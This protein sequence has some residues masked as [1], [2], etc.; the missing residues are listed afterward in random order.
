MASRY[1]NLVTAMDVDGAAVSCYGGGMNCVNQVAAPPLVIEQSAGANQLLDVFGVSSE[2]VTQSGERDVFITHLRD[3]AYGSG[4]VTSTSAYGNNFSATGEAYVIRQNVDQPNC[5]LAEPVGSVGTSASVALT[6]DDL[7]YT[8]FTGRYG[9]IGNAIR[10][11]TL[12]N[13]GC[14]PPDAGQTP[15]DLNPPILFNVDL[16][17]VVGGNDGR[18][19]QLSTNGDRAFALVRSPD[20]LVVLRISGANAAGLGIHPSSVAPLPPG[21]TELLPIPRVSSSGAPIGDLVAVSCADSNTLAFYD[22]ELGTVTASL[23][24]VGNE[25]FA[26]VSSLR[27]VGVGPG[28][29]VLPG[30]RLFVTDFGSGQIAVVDVPDLTDARSAQVVAFIGTWEDTSASPINPNNSILNVPIG[31]GPSGIP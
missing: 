7:I 24:N 30:I 26:I 28:A 29:Q 2:I 14:L 8:L 19:I 9:G 18:G 21:P 31:G 27:T 10:I 20:S 1:S 5:R 12:P 23:P 16:S 13:G 4:G 15:V 11:L 6:Q 22:D 25:P 17:F 3:Q